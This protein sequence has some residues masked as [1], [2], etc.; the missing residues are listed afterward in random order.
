MLSRTAAWKENMYVRDLWQV[1]KGSFLIWPPHL[2]SDTSGER[3]G[4]RKS[5]IGL[6]S[7]WLPD[8]ELLHSLSK[9]L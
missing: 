9:S 1:N 8:G 3:G 7:Y 2:R 6:R 4:G 5:S